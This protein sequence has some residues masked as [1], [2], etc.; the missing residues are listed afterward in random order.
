MLAR[1]INLTHWLRFPPGHGE[2]ALARYLS[3]ADL[4]ALHRAGF[5][6]LR[7]AVQPAVVRGRP[8]LLIATIRRIQ[9]HGLGVMVGWHLPPGALADTRQQQALLD[10]W[11]RTAPALRPLDAR[12]TFPEVVNEPDIPDAAWSDLQPRI[13]ARIR[14]ALPDATVVLT[15]SRWGSLAGLRAHDPLPDGNVVYSF[16]SYEPP[17]L[18][19][20]GSFEAGLDHRALARL[21]VP[22][23]R[24]RLRRRRSRHPAA[25]HAGR[26]ALVLRRTLG[27]RK[28]RR[29]HSRRRRV[30]AT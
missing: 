29:R 17:V 7:L 3:D 30:V 1:G 24:S 14:Q 2:Q 8:G 18:T 4:E 11:D 9:S 19:T 22:G 28:S 21:P 23:Q 27:Q 6:F 5:T 12:L 26:H 25:A 16:H 20:L 10:L 15:G 13:L